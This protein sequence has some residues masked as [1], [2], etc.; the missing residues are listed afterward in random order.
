MSLVGKAPAGRQ[1]GLRI[2]GAVAHARRF[3][4]AEADLSSHPLP[5]HRS[6]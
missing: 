6:C 3:L 5:V 2:R 1:G 4:L